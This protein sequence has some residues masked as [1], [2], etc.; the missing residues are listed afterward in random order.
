M[1]SADLLPRDAVAEVR[2]G[3][4]ERDIPASAEER[5]RPVS[6]P[7]ENMNSAPRFGSPPS[8][9]RTTAVRESATRRRKLVGRGII[10]PVIAWST[11]GERRKGHTRGDGGR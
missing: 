5:L 11:P 4:G 10:A 3:S 7:A 1:A 6:S 2:A 9:S 8:W